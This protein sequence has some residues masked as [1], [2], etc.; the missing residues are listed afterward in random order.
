MSARTNRRSHAATAPAP[1]PRLRLSRIPILHGADLTTRLLAL[2]EARSGQPGP[3][4]WLTAGI[5]GD[6]VGGIVVVQEVFARLRKRPLRAGRLS[7]FPLLN[8]FGFETASRRIPSTSEDLNRAFPGDPE[9][10]LAA[11]I[12]H[13][14]SERIRTS[15]PDLVID[16]HNDWLRSIP[17]ALIDPRPATREGRAAHACARAAAAASGLPIVDEPA[18]AASRATA[19]TTLSGHLLEL[20]VAAL[21]LELG[22]A[23][24]VEEPG[25]Q[26]AADRVWALLAR[27]GMVD[28]GTEADGR[29]GEGPP[30][31][32][33]YQ[34]DDRPWPSKAGIVRFRVQP[35][36]H[37]TRGTPLASI[38]DVF[39]RRIE[40]LRA[41]SDALVLG[42][43]DSALA[44][45]GLPVVALARR[46]P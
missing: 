19:R 5:H 3:A 20:G 9:G 38:H 27:L 43:S 15:A 7:G 26:G 33:G 13:V 35:G 44:V 6:E 14:V 2:I 22:A 25:V 4:V 42:Y 32:P 12:A 8:P 11:R 36:A 30:P 45:P 28:D 31:S 34:Y 18:T 21:T 39:G 24:T 41:A 46:E 16:L 1:R 23:G 29:A 40:L 37:V 17:Y 10:S